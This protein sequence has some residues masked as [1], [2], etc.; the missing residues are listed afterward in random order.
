VSAGRR[1]LPLSGFGRWCRPD[2]C[3]VAT[4]TT[5]TAPVVPRCHGRRCR[6]R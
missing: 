3:A 5:A 6:R 1:S 4:E 2:L